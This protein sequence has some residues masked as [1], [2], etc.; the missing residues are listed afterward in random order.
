M[1]GR[2]IKVLFIDSDWEIF[3]QEGPTKIA[4]NNK[5]VSLSWRPSSEKKRLSSNLEKQE[6]KVFNKLCLSYDH[7]C[8]IRD[9]YQKEREVVEK[10]DVEQREKKENNEDP[11][12]VEEALRQLKK[13]EFGAV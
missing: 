12:V 7:T 2:E 1:G 3:F 10:V 4:M 6:K 11:K 9:L 8:K 13:L 5:E